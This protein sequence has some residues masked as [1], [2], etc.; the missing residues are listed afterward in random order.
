MEYACSR[1]CTWWSGEK[2]GFL[3]QI[4]PDSYN[5]IIYY[6]SADTFVTLPGLLLSSSFFL[7]H[8]F[9]RKKGGIFSASRK[10]SHQTTLCHSFK[11]LVTWRR[12]P[13]FHFCSQSYEYYEQYCL[14]SFNKAS[15]SGWQ[16]IHFSFVLFVFLAFFPTAEIQSSDSDWEK[17]V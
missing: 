15:K 2:L 11:A 16:K 17:K 10:K 14:P 12:R 8:S 3:N 13:T 4:D 1:V 6:R 5:P 9:E 7:L